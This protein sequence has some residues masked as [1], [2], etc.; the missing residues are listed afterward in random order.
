MLSE[1]PDSTAISA[2][3]MACLDASVLEKITG[4]R[5]VNV[6]R[7]GKTRVGV[8]G[9]ATGVGNGIG[10]IVAAEIAEAI[11]VAVVVVVVVVVVAGGV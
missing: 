1:S 10:E 7:A 3:V 8:A 4:A 5:F 11:D 2:E 9:G 6:M